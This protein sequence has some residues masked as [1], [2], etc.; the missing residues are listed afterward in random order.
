MYADYLQKI[1]KATKESHQSLLISSPLYLRKSAS[2]CGSG[3]SL[4]YLCVF[5]ALREFLFFFVLFV[6]ARIA[7]R[8]I[9]GVA[10]SRLFVFHPRPVRIL[11]NIRSSTYF[12][13]HRSRVEVTRS[14]PSYGNYQSSKQTDENK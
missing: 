8:S 5:A 2:I 11:R 9:A 7:T 3:F 6:P 14:I 10:F 4:F 13:R 12:Q 1:T